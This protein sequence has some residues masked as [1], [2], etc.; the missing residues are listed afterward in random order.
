MNEPIALIVGVTPK[1]IADQMRTGSGCGDS[2][3]VKNDRTKS[4]KLSANTSSPAA[5]MAGHS[6]GSVTSRNVC[7]RVAPR[8]SAAFST[9]CPIE[10][11]RPRTTT[12]TYEIENVMWP[13]MIVVSESCSPIWV[14]SS[15]ADDARHDLG[16]DQREQHQHVRRAAQARARP[17]QPVGE[18][19]P[20]GGGDD[21]RDERDLDAREQRVAQRLAL[22]EGLVPPQAE[23]VEVLQRPGGVER[24]QHHQRDRREQD[25]EEQAREQPQEHG[26][27]EVLRRPRALRAL[28]RDRGRCLRDRAH[29]VAS[30][31]A[32]AA[33]RR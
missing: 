28:G 18:Q 20:D 1:R 6:S 12:V 30:R 5:R 10:A 7:Q 13:R 2:P 3:V 25:E 9:S 21:H 19:R 17:H 26:T 11:K 31:A 23:P 16:R 14:N 22:E 4:S 24:E 33:E 32:R 15:S 8:S 27:V 29:A